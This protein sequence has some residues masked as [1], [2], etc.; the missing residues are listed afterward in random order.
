[1]SNCCDQNASCS[2]N[3]PVEKKDSGVAPQR[4][5]IR[6][7]IHQMDCPTEE[8]LIRDALAPLPGVRSLEFNLMQR[9]LTV[10]RDPV[11][12]AAVESVLHKLGFT[13]QRVTPDMDKSAN[14][15]SGAP[16]RTRWLLLA[17]SGMTATGAEAA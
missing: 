14:S 16:N 10:E 13:P 11:A 9:M 2:A 6:Y 5:A 3:P 17:L 15:S 1:M 12:D 8:K 4:D 7:L